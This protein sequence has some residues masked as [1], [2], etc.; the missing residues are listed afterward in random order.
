MSE[1]DPTMTPPRHTRRFTAERDEWTAIPGTDLELL[2]T[3]GRPATVDV[4]S[5]FDP[6][7]VSVLVSAA[8]WVRI[9]E[10]SPV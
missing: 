4:V 10:I 8:G 6:L 2:H 9:R 3:T 7:E 5:G 1:H